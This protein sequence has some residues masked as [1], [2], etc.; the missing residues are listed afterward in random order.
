MDMSSYGTD[1]ALAH[2]IEAA[3]QRKL[4]II[5]ENHMRPQHRIFAKKVI[6]ELAKHGFHHLGLETFSSITDDNVLL[7]SELESRG[8]PL[9]SPMT[10]TYTLEP[11]MGE[12][13]RDAI[14]VGYNLFA[15]EKMGRDKSGRDRDEIQAG[16]II[17]YLQNNPEAKI[18]ILCGFHHAIESDWLKR[19]KYFWM[20]KY[21]K[22][23]IDI[24]PLT[25]YQDNFTEK[26]NFNQHPILKELSI[27]EPSVFV[28]A[29]KKRVHV[30][31]HVDMEIVHPM[32]YYRYGRPHWLFQNDAYKAVK[33]T[34]GDEAIYPII[35]SAHRV[36]EISGA[37]I[38][39]IELKYQYDNKNLVLPNGKY[40]VKL[41]DSEKE[42][43]ND[44]VVE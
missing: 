8:Y 43:S 25:I 29:S 11:Q 10:G 13:V 31:D 44:I 42:L 37:A 18:V 38:D 41:L 22:D 35:V 21:L 7:D 5:S 19:N 15:Y 30:T 27:T 34:I 4:V 33:P 17:R 26:I 12:L 23:K 32:T 20:A 16:N 6:K 24:D 2:I 1:S 14:S 9:N 36:G 40:T 28:D 39:C 3:A